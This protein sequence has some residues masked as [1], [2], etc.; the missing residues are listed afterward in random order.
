[1]N[2][3]TLEEKFKAQSQPGELYEFTEKGNLI[4]LACGHECVI[5]EGR[6]GVCNVRFNE[7]GQLLVPHNYVAGLQS[8]PIE[9]KPFFHVAPGTDALSF[10]MLGCDFQCDYCQNWVT[11]QSL[12]DPDAT[13][14]MKETTVPDLVDRAER[15]GVKSIVS[16]YNE[17]LI[18]SEWA[19]EVFDEAKRRSD[20][21]C[22]FVS[23]GNA[24]ERVLDYLEP[25]TDLYKVDL[26][27]FRDRTYRQLGGELEN[28]LRT[29]EMLN[30]KDFWLEIVTLVVPGF[31]DDE[32]ELRDIAQ[33]IAGIS[34]DIPWHVTAFHPD[35]E[36]TN[37]SNTRAEQLLRIAEMGRAEGLNFVYIG[38]VPG[39]VDDFENTYCPECDELLVEREG[40]R[41]LMQRI[42]AEGH[43]SQ[44]ERS[45]PGRWCDDQVRGDD[46]NPGR[47]LPFS[48]SVRS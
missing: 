35:Y 1:M 13:T 33:F 30:E 42:T 12:R 2:T 41:V 18:T 15:D 44:C 28:T 22:G 43:C 11:S 27:S 45:I 8:D 6:S 21:F 24:T 14:R 48:I 7:D 29:I 9:K 4:C 40:H 23:N 3:E 25:V 17:P 16:T 36:M 34:E 32:E 39:R 10:G 19:R 38:N 20:Y 46:L 26:K 37:Q 47:R 5:R 31:N